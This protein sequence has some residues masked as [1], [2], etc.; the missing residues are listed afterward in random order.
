MDREEYK[1]SFALS[2]ENY[3]GLDKQLMAYVQDFWGGKVWGMLSCRKRK[4]DYY[5][6]ASSFA[7]LSLAE[8]MER[9]AAGGST[10]TK[11]KKKSQPGDFFALQ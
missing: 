9:K 2:K 4:K 7:K 10:F 6:K 1:I 11:K 5:T 3:L 8:S